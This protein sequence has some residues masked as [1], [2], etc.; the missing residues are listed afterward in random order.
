MILLVHWS[1]AKKGFQEWSFSIVHMHIDHELA[2]KKNMRLFQY[3]ADEIR[4]Y[5][6]TNET[7]KMNE[8]FAWQS[9]LIWEDKYRENLNRNRH[10]LYRQEF[11]G[12]KNF[13]KLFR[14]E[15]FCLID[16]G[17]SRF[18]HLLDGL[19][20]STGIFVR[21]G[22]RTNTDDIDESISKLNLDSRDK[23][24]DLFS[25]M[26]LYEEIKRKHRELLDK[27]Y[28]CNIHE[29]I[30]RNMLSHFIPL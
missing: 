12:W 17:N 30:V 7:L 5:L 8:P 1:N 21:I 20:Q 26:P 4:N 28:W 29:T 24:N 10:H 22:Q 16:N 11:E 18:E 19:C 9:K 14:D 13:D 15:K 6:E 23:L 27:Y 3:Y 25:Q 2:F